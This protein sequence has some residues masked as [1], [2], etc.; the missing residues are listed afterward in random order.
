M[1]YPD[2]M[3][4][5]LPPSAAGLIE[6]ASLEGEEYLVRCAAWLRQELDVFAVSIGELEGEKV[7]SVRVIGFAR[8]DGEAGPSGYALNG[9]PCHQ[10]VDS[11]N[12]HCV[13]EDAKGMYPEDELFAKF[14]I[15][16]YVGIP[17]RDGFGRTFGLVC[18]FDDKPRG[19]TEEM[20][21]LIEWLGTRIG[22][23]AGSVRTRRNLANSVRWMAPSQA[24][25]VFIN[26]TAHLCEVLQVT[27]SLIMEWPEDQPGYARTMTLLHQGQRL[28]SGRF[29]EAGSTF[30]HLLCRT[31]ESGS[32]CLFRTA[33]I[34]QPRMSGTV[35]ARA[36]QLPGVCDQ[37]SRREKDWPSGCRAHRCARARSRS[38]ACSGSVSGASDRR[39]RAS[40]DGSG[41]G[42]N[43][44]FTGCETQA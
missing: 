39:A 24:R 6:L 22:S 32:D 38:L 44:A 5:N 25:D 30:R 36:E 9:T 1:A 28:E 12:S 20:L 2:E 21:A 33:G 17:L 26:A 8:R 4:R 19:D 3:T 42:G 13:V 11:R 16:S 35:R 40:G 27:T 41:T 34:C 23:E 18:V 29:A 10:V 14:A 15:D 43:R 37:R 31:R 7:E